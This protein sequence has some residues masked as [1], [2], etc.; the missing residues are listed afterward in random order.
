MLT[1]WRAVRFSTKLKLL[2]RLAAAA[3]EVRANGAFA[4]MPTS[5][6]FSTAGH[7]CSRSSCSPLACDTSIGAHPPS[8]HM[9][10]SGEGDCICWSSLRQSAERLVL[11]TALTDAE[12][13][14]GV[15]THAHQDGCVRWLGARL[16]SGHVCV[17]GSQAHHS[18]GR[19][20]CGCLPQD[21]R[22]PP[23]N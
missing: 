23:S 9:Q 12:R 22:Q 6:Q 3:I 10:N 15:G 8:C 16:T 13:G 1:D 5:A 14:E 7:G 4:G 21:Q 20:A 19:A 18:C 11:I 2:K 17:L